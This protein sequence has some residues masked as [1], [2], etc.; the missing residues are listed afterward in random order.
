M[1]NRIL[2]IMESERLTPSGF[3]EEIGIKR[4]AMSHI[5]KGRNNPSLDVCIKILE[6]FT[7]VNPDWLLKGTGNMKRDAKPTSLMPDL[8]ST[9]VH[10]PPE[11]KIIPEYRTEIEGKK[12]KIPPK[13]EEI[14]PVKYTEAPVKKVVKIIIYYS[15]TT[16]ETFNPEK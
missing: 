2:Q 11:K 7:Y 12:M 9:P 6:R 8:F 13:K 5:T 1:I 4:A 16:Y 14:E 10:I 15:D 3:A